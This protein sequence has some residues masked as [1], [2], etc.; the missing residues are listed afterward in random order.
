MIVLAINEEN[1]E[2][3]F[4]PETAGGQSEE[5]DSGGAATRKEGH[6]QTV[7]ASGEMEKGKLW[8]L[9]R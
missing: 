5:E 6:A 4:G 3:L 9:H 1:L 2:L 8:R 7:R